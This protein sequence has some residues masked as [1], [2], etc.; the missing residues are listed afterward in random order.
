MLIG[1]GPPPVALRG[2][3]SVASALERTEEFTLDAGADPRRAISRD[4]PADDLSAFVRHSMLDAC[5]TADRL[6]R[7][8]KARDDGVRYPGGSLGER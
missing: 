3:R 8:S 5:A 2:R 6:A 7:V 4:E 1:S